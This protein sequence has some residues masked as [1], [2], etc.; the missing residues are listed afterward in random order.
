MIESAQGNRGPVHLDDVDA[1]GHDES[2]AALV[3]ALPALEKACSAYL[4]SEPSVMAECADDVR[5]LLNS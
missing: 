4:L 1:L 5:E 2:L 3:E